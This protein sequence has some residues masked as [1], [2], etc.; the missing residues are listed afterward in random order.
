MKYVCKICGKTYD[1]S[2]EGWRCQCGHS[3]W[4][5]SEV[6]FH[7]ED[8]RAYDFSMWRYDKAYPVHREDVVATFGEGMTPFVPVRWNG[9]TVYFKNE[10]LMP[11]GSFKDRGVAMMINFIKRQGINKITEDSSGNAGAAVSA[12][13]A[14][15][16]LECNVFVPESTS[17][18]KVAQIAC[19]GAHLHKIPGRRDN[20]AEAAQSVS[21]GVYAGHNWHPMFVEGVKSIAYEIWEQNGFEAPDNIRSVR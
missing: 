3:L 12:Y 6:N 5:A 10:S 18:G 21:D 20:A 15:A 17:Q 7:R 19:F 1:E 16:G 4:L 9:S 11:T 13:S 14:R 2:Y 8:I